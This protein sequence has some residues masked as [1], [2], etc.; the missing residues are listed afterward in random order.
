MRFPHYVR[1]YT[2]E[3]GAYDEA[4]GDY[5]APTETVAYEGFADVQDVG[6]VLERDESGTVTLRSDA[7]L[8]LQEPVADPSVF[9]PEMNVDI[10]WNPEIVTDWDSFNWDAPPAGAD[11]AD[12]ETI[13]F[14][15]LDSKLHLRW[16]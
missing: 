15:R 4:T 14:V 6:A 11:R 7:V 10:L 12:A 1:V 3:P 8:F 2:S 9:E 5:G 16:L 13:R